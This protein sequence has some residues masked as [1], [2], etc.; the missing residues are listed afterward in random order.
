MLIKI[1][2]TCWINPQNVSAVVISKQNACGGNDTANIEFTL[3][4]GQTLRIASTIPFSESEK[5]IDDLVSKLNTKGNK[6]KGKIL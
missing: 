4:G 1:S 2:S 6:L 3:H 5:Y